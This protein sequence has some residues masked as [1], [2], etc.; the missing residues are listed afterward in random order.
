MMLILYRSKKPRS[1]HHLFSPLE[2][3]LTPWAAISSIVLGI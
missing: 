3:P 1:R 2:A